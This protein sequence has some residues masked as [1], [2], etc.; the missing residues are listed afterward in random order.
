M[1]STI[2]IAEP[3]DLPALVAIY[4]AAIPGRMATADTEPV[5]VGQRE[6]WFASFDPASRPLWVLET[7]G[8]VVAWLSFRSFYGRPA[9]GHTVET[10]I[11]VA[12]G[13][14]RQGHAGRLLSHAIGE[15]PGLG[16]RTLLALVFAHNEASVSLFARHGFAGWGKLPRVAELD[17][18]ERDL[19][20]MGRRVD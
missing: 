5:T 11:Y 9:Y 10:G 18:I 14:Q 6:E 12:P 20:I 2:R 8:G 16:I 7:D 3:R 1:E 13:H 4:N 15:A 19:L 17:G